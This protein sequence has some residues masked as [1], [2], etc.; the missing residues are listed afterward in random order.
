MV[1]KLEYIFGL[2]T[3]LMLSTDGDTI[4]IAIRGSRRDYSLLWRKVELNAQI[5]TRYT[6]SL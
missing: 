2:K 3:K 1:F 5:H 6:D 4:Y